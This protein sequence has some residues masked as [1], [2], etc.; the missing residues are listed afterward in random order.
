MPLF[1]CGKTE[2]ITPAPVYSNY[3]CA[4][5][6]ALNV[7]EHAGSSLG[8][9]RNTSVTFKIRNHVATNVSGNVGHD[10]WVME[11]DG[12]IDG[13]VRVANASATATVQNRSSVVRVLYADDEGQ[14]VEEFN[15][16]GLID[17]YMNTMKMCEEEANSVATALFDFSDMK[18]EE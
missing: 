12:K 6:Q 9:L 2:I 16:D 7:V 14:H 3:N 18:D 5:S 8:Y 1:R 11:F 13:Y 15:Y 10:C 17:F 4:C